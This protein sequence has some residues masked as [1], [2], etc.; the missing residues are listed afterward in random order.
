MTLNDFRTFYERE[1]ATTRKVL[2]AFPAA[3]ADFRPHE[4]S[5]TALQLG[6]IFVAEEQMISRALRS[7]PVL[8]SGARPAPT[9]WQEVLDGFD[10]V[11]Q[12]VMQ[13]LASATE[14][15]LKPVAFYVAPKTPG[16]WPCLL[17]ACRETCWVAR[18]TLVVEPPE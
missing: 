10:A 8:G 2:Q 17:R 1:H 4:R 5:S 16:E 3:R 7:E 6:A 14:A 13:A 15:E 12:D 18:L 11:H 9:S